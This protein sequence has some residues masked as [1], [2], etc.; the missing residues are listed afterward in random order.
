MGAEFSISRRV[1]FAETDMAGVVHFSNY[2]RWMEEVEHAYFRAAGLSVVMQ[3]EGREISWPR[4]AVGC[5]YFGPLRFEDEL[6]L[7][8]RVMKVGEKSFTYEVDFMKG[9]NQVALGKVTSVCCA[10]QPQRGF[11]AIAIPAE[12]KEKLVAG[13]G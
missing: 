12:I 2:F 8:L 3:H 7:R 9:G 4:V 11:A 13:P 6:E 1:Q 5:E 10:V